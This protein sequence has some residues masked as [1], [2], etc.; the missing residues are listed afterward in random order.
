MIESIASATPVYLYRD[1]VDFRKSINGLSV[2]V[3]DA[4][5]LDVF[6]SA[7]FV[8]CNRNRRQVKILYWQ[9]NGFCLWLKRLEKDKFAW[10]RKAAD[11]T[12]TIDQSQLNWLLDGF[13]IF[14]HPPHETLHFRYTG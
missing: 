6:S 9:K 14:K 1:A 8:F 7:L 12:L 13:D 11:G 10:P 2:I 4:M 3:Q 5:T